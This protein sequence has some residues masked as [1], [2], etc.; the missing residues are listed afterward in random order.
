MS[1]KPVV[2]LMGDSV[3]VHVADRIAQKLDDA[4]DVVAS[5]SVRTS[6]NL[7]AHLGEWLTDGAKIVCFNCGLHDLSRDRQTHAFNHYE[8]IDRNQVLERYRSNLEQIIKWLQDQPSVTQVIWQTITPVIDQ[9][10]QRVK[11]F[12]RRQDDVAA[13]NE[14]ALGVVAA[15]GLVV[16]DRHQV[17]VAAG[18]EQSLRPDGVHMT[19][20]GLEV[21]ATATAGFVRG[22][23]GGIVCEY[24][25]VWVWE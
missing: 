7:L 6:G 20:S 15:S 12:D 21:L 10:H 13:F 19:E 17:I 23:L 3:T 25:G 5:P 22:R 14:A 1:N 18:V 11:T 24:V 9:R 16:H 4:A 2:Q 8:T